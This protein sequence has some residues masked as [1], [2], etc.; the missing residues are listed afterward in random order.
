MGNY[1]PKTF[2]YRLQN[3][4]GRS[5]KTYNKINT[6]RLGFK[7]NTNN[8]PPKIQSVHRKA[9]LLNS[10]AI[11][12]PLPSAKRRLH[13]W[14]VGDKL[15]RNLPQ[16]GK[17]FLRALEHAGLVVVDTVL[18]AEGLHESVHL[19]EVVAGDLGEEVVIHLVLEPAAEPVD[20]RRARHVPRSSDLVV[21]C[22]VTPKT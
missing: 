17:H 3:K 11:P 7:K 8:T 1:L 20:E 6:A 12:P 9:Q 14:E 2:S 22:T 13:G 15:S 5:E 4:A 10:P 16:V 19:A 21:F 18:L